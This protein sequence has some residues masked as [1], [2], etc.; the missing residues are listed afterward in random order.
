MRKYINNIL[1]LEIL[2]RDEILYYSSSSDDNK[3]TK[4]LNNI[5]EERMKN[6][7]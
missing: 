3:T 4:T 2:E 1:E 6:I 7:N 5:N